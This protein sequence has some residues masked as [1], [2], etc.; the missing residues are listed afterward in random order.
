MDIEGKGYL[1]MEEEYSEQDTGQG[2]IAK[3]WNDTTTILSLLRR[4]LD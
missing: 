4:G 1:S 2:E 3:I